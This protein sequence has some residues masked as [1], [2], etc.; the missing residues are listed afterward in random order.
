MESATRRRD[1]EHGIQKSDRSISKTDHSNQETE[2]SIS[3]TDHVIQ[4]T[5]LPI[6]KIQRLSSACIRP[7]KNC[8]SPSGSRNLPS[9]NRN[10]PSENRDGPSARHSENRR[11]L[12]NAFPHQWGSGHLG[13]GQAGRLSPPG[14]PLLLPTPHSRLT[15]F[16]NQPAGTPAPPDHPFLPTS[17]LSPSST[18][19]SASRRRGPRI[20]RA[21]RACRL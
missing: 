14:E 5:D 21:R 7:K 9:E 11:G 10:G 1:S 17:L 13:I 15:T 4:K 18:S 2:R 19:S 3:R 16:L 6:S 20:S 12:R 8:N